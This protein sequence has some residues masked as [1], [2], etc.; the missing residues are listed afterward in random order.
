VKTDVT[1]RYSGLVLKLK[2]VLAYVEKIV[3]I[4][5]AVIII[6]NDIFVLQHHYTT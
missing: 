3:C 4:T 1:N 5:V 2:T 6:I